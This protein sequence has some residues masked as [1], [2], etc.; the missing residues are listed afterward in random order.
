MI[1]AVTVTTVPTA[2]I[3]PAQAYL[4]W[5]LIENNGDAPVFLKLDE[6]STALTAANGLPILPG[7]VF[8]YFDKP[9]VFHNVIQGITASGTQNVRVQWGT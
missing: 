3:D 7:T 6:S 5:F 4:R 8:S 9:S 1:A 2:L